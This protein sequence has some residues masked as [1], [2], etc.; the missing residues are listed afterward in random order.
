MGKNKSFSDLSMDDKFNQLWSKSCSESATAK[1]RHEEVTCRLKTLSLRVDKIESC[2]VKLE[3]KHQMVCS[4]VVK[5]KSKVNELEQS[6][7]NCDLIIRGVPEVEQ[8]ADDLY[9]IVQLILQKLNIPPTFNI[10][11][12]QR[13]GKPRE[14]NRSAGS[15]Y[16]LLQLSQKNEKDNILAAKKKIK[17]TCD[18]LILDNDRPVGSGKQIIYFDERLTKT[19][20]ELFYAARLLRKDRIIKHAWVR[21]GIVHIRKEDKSVAVRITEQ[22]QLRELERKR[23][24]SSTPN[25]DD[26]NMYE[27]PMDDDDDEILQPPIKNPNKKKRDDKKANEGCKTRATVQLAK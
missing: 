14:Q 15:R 26:S 6:T 12:V 25:K 27:S 16:I 19:T 11:T 1:Q 2:T 3:Q 20:S 7:L 4:E 22:S 13:L 9:T 18:Q 8:S 17:I 5:L 10:S 21:N 23:R 24:C